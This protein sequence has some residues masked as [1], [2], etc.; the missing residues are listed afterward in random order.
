M[1]A[2]TKENLIIEIVDADTGAI[3]V[4]D[5]FDHCIECDEGVAHEADEII[6]ALERGEFYSLGG[7]AAAGYIIRPAP[8]SAYATA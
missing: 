2:I 3:V 8:Q 6:A 1:A 5:R 7:G 4:C